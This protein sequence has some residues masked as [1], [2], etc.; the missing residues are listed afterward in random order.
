MKTISFELSKRLN[1]SWL[2]DD[3]DTDFLYQLLPNNKKNW[4]LKHKLVKNWNWEWR[5]YK[6]LTLAEAIEF[7]P[8]FNLEK[9]NYKDEEWNIQLTSFNLKINWYETWEKKELVFAIEKLL[10]Y[11]LDKFLQT[12]SNERQW[13]FIW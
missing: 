8:S 2:L 13:D 5:V 9:I 7:L 4:W 10:E 12:L 3:I 11:L 1:E 6:T